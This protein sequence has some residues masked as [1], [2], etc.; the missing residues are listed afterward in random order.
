MEEKTINTNAALQKPL[1]QNLTDDRLNFENFI[2]LRLI[3]LVGIVVLVIGL[4]IGVKYAIDRRFFLKKFFN[5][6]IFID[7]CKRLH[8][9]L[10]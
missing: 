8:S 4:S 5:S 3:H 6:K 10:Y 7:L 2:G 9:L 1:K